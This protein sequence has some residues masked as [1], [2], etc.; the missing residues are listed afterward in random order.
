MYGGYGYGGGAVP[1]DVETLPVPVPVKEVEVEVE[2]VELVAVTGDAGEVLEFDDVGTP[3][4]G[5]PELYGG[6]GG[7]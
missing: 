4:E 2:D 7:G 5:T 1:D 6:G 3:D